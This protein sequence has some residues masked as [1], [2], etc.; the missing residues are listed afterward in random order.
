MFFF[1]NY[2]DLTGFV[3]HLFIRGFTIRKE[4]QIC[5]LKLAYCFQAD[6]L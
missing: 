4:I 3:S 2:F 5:F 6:L 1:L